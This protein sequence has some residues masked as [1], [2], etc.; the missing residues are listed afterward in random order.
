[1]HP[2]RAPTPTERNRLLLALPHADYRA[3]LPD[4]ESV[5]I[6]HGAVLFEARER[7]THVF[8]P[9]R[10]VVSM[11]AA[12]GDGPAVEVGLVGNEGMVGLSAFLGATTSSTQAVLQIPDGAWR[13]D[14]RAFGRAVARGTA[15]RQAMQR[16]T[17]TVI[18]HVAQVL[19]CNQQH[20]VSRRCARWLLMAH[21][22]VGADQ[23]TLTQDF[24]GQMLGA[25]RPTVSLT[26]GRLQ[27]LG[28]IRYSRGVI[29]VTDRAGLED[30]ACTC[31]DVMEEDYARAFAADRQAPPPRSGSRRT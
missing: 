28:L 12:A 13:M 27:G 31:Y 15:L 23:F 21:D 22:R 6:E 9:Q 5:I 14:V 19:A 29:T 16:Y 17:Q 24:L 8:F 25:Q 10:C 11:L 3:L 30:A 7:L 26:A 2:P 4:L 18:S 1:M 20:T